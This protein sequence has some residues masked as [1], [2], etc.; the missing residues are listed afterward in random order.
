MLARAILKSIGQC[1]SDTAISL[2]P[3]HRQHHAPATSR[4]DYQFHALKTN[5]NYCKL[6][7]RC[8]GPAARRIDQ[9]AHGS[10]CRVD[11][12]DVYKYGCR[13]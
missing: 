12:S 3:K 11:H 6:S 5:V 13:R 2:I 1:E 4:H 7:S 10:N 8:Q 9:F